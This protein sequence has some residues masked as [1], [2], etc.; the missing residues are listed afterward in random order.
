MPL[1][2]VVEA[3]P[4]GGGGGALLGMTLRTRPALSVYF[5]NP[6]KTLAI[7]AVGFIHYGFIVYAYFYT[8]RDD[9]CGMN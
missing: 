1:G 2:E 6:V 9:A 5:K 7:H 8:F 4:T 3:V